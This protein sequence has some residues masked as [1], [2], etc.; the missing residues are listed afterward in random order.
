MAD[1]IP[2]CVHTLFR[3][4]ARSF[5]STVMTTATTMGYEIWLQAHSQ[6]KARKPGFQHHMGLHASAQSD[7]HLCYSS[8]EKQSN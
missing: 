6:A 4:V 8:S 3:G 5:A 2:T 1:K 7:Q